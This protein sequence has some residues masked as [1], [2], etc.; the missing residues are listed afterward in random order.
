MNLTLFRIPFERTNGRGSAPAIFIWHDH[1]C[2]I[3]PENL[4]DVRCSF[5]L[6]VRVADAHGPRAY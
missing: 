4:S 1:T 2:A 5:G 3:L 6:P